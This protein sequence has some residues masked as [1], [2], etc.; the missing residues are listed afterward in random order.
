MATI[1]ATNYHLGTKAKFVHVYAGVPFTTCTRSIVL[2][3]PE[4]KWDELCA[5][6]PDAIKTS[7]KSDSKYIVLQDRVYR[8]ADH[9]GRVAS[10]DWDVITKT[11]DLPD[12]FVW[13][14]WSLGV[15]FYSE[16]TKNND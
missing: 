15:A 1:D 2:D 7:P 9:W 10:C 16:M 8:Y 5:M 12:N 11:S 3:M 6:Y 14:K 4:V 13:G